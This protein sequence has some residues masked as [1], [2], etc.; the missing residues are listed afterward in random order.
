MINIQYLPSNSIKFKDN[1]F[2]PLISIVFI[3]YRKIKDNKVFL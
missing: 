2:N 1:I 3:L